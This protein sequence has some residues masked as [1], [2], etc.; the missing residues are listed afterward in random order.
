[1]L[2]RRPALRQEPALR[3]RAMGRPSL[4]LRLLLALLLLPPP[5]PL[6]W[7]L[8]PAPCPEPCSCPPDGAL[9]CPGPQAG[10]SRL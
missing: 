6:L 7:A 4:A 10:L 1:M 2:G 3:L 5:A 8:R 9:R